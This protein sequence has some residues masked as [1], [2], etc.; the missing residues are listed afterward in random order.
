MGMLSMRIALCVAL[1]VSAT[2]LPSGKTTKATACYLTQDGELT[3]IDH[4]ISWT[5][6]AKVHTWR[7]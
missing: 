2:A 3:P 7:Q 1:V 5:D 4:D 6:L